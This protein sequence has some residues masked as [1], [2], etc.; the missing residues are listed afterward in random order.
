MCVGSPQ[1]SERQHRCGNP[2]SRQMHVMPPPTHDA[3]LRTVFVPG[4]VAFVIHTNA[5]ERDTNVR[6]QYFSSMSVQKKESLRQ[7]AQG[8]CRPLAVARETGGSAERINPWKTSQRR[9][10]ANN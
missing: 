6:M 7:E 2:S 8:G 4:F 1:R 3:I 5:L 9:V 10:V